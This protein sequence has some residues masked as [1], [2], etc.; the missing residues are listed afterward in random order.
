MLA[1]Y[2]ENEFPFYIEKKIQPKKKKKTKEAEA[3]GGSP[4]IGIAVISRIES[5]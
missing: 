2:K 4:K 3:L 5:Q 1:C